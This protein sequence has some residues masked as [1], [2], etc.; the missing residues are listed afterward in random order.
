LLKQ[1]K[2]VILSA[3]SR[4]C[5]PQPKDLPSRLHPRNCSTRSTTDPKVSPKICHLDRSI[6]ASCDAQRRDLH[7]LLLLPCF[8][9]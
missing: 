5:E 6:A 3:G 2:F 9:F 1:N 8:C 7:R 4:F